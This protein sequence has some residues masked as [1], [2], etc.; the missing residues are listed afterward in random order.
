MSGCA[1]CAFDCGDPVIASDPDGGEFR[2][3][4]DDN[5]KSTFTPIG[6]R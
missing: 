4:H 1:A 6:N 5:D 3:G 2:V